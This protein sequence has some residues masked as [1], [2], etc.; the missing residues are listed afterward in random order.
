[1][2]VGAAHPK[3]SIEVAFGGGEG[4]QLAHPGGCITRTGAVAEQRLPLC[5]ARQ[6]R[7]GIACMIIYNNCMF[8]M[9][10]TRLHS[11]NLTRAAIQN[12]SGEWRP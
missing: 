3:S 4:S 12:N 11:W 5:P 1:M 10:D 7:V 2:G 8:Y 9:D 6:P